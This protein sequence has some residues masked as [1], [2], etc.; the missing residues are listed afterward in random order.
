MDG[1]QDGRA[2]VDAH[3]TW[4]ADVILEADADAVIVWA[5]PSVEQVW[6]WTPEELVGR[7]GAW[8]VHPDDL[9]IREGMFAQIRATGAAQGRLRIRRRNDTFTWMEGWVRPHPE[10]GGFLLAIRSVD[11]QVAAEQQ[12]QALVAELQARD[13]AMRAAVSSMIDPFMILRGEHD[14]TGTLVDAV[15][16]EVNTAAAEYLRLSPGD[17]VGRRISDFFTGPGVETV[18]GWCHRA[19]STGRPV[20]LD[21]EQM[22]SSVDGSARWLDVRAVPVGD[23]VT[24][25][26]R[27]QTARHA[28]RE[29]L[30]VIADHADALMIVSTDGDVVWMAP[31]LEAALEVDAGGW[32]GSPLADHVDPADP[33]G[34]SRLK[35]LL[36]PGGRPGTCVARVLVRPD[37][38]HMVRFESLAPVPVTDGSR[39]VPVRARPVGVEVQAAMHAYEQAIEY[40]LLTDHARE[41]VLTTEGGRI[42]WVSPSLYR[43]LGWTPADWIGAPLAS[44][45]HPEDAPVL[46]EVLEQEQVPIRMRNRAD[47][48]VWFVLTCSPERRGRRV[49]TCSLLPA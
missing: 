21:D 23:A 6:G 40:S 16:L 1:R 44:V 2:E 46:A 43:L 25:T 27:D 24:L 26:W 36:G 49:Y 19:I 34:A 4:A 12:L 7:T 10:T 5:S 39:V 31:A 14:G 28:R 32:L 17:V 45:L 35:P 22:T 18:L 30:Q 9:A 38:V 37:S 48:D 13:E 20:V 29:L 33:A 47:M 11:E 15:Y 3:P 41:I 42:A 8:L